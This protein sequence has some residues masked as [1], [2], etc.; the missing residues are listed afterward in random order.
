MQ[1]WSYGFDVLDYDFTTIDGQRVRVLKKLKVYEVSPVLLGAGI[2]T[3]TVTVKGRSESVALPWDPPTAENLVAAAEAL[4]HEAFAVPHQTRVAAERGAFEAGQL[5]GEPMPSVRFFEKF[6]GCSID[7]AAG[8]PSA[9]IWV[10]AF[11]RAGR[12][13]AI[14]AHETAHAAG[15]SDEWSCR[16]LANVIARMWR[17]PEVKAFGWRGEFSHRDPPY[18]GQAVPYAFLVLRVGDVL[19][20]RWN[21]GSKEL[22]TWRR[23]TI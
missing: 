5:L 16:K 17:D 14:A 8:V 6:P 23:V 11:L 22:P 13:A 7:G 3:R 4:E 21:K 18:R 12:A 20:I 15:I 9:E 19:D 2:G 10:G 1:E